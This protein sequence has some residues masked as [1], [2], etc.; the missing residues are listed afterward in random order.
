MGGNSLKSYGYFM[1]SL[2]L[3]VAIAFGM[4]HIFDI[5]AREIDSA[6]LVARFF[7]IRLC[8][9]ALLLV[10]WLVVLPR[11]IEHTMQ[12]QLYVFQDHA[13]MTHDKALR[14]EQEMRDTA[15]KCNTPAMMAKLIGFILLFEL[16]LVRQCQL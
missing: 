3:V 2:A 15:R 4:I 11:L 14:Y 9:Y 7:P 1:T 16:V 8:I 10:F 6:N 13:D 12:K 5:T